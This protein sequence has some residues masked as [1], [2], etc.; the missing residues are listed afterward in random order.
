MTGITEWLTGLTAA[1]LLGVIATGMA[2][3]DNRA[4]RLTVGLVL[5]LVL[6][7]PIAAF[8]LTDVSQML[9]KARTEA[10]MAVTNIEVENQELLACIISE[11]TATYILDKAESLGMHLSVKVETRQGTYYP[12]PFSVTLEGNTTTAQRQQLSAWITE[13]LAIA[14]ENL[15]WKE[16]NP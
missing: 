5:L 3:E 7:S 15:I 6:S 1:A 9:A 16:L 11:Q 14:E 4:V 10:D 12:Y 2:G 13:Q 8:D